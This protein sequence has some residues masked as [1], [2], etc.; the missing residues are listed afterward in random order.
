MPLEREYKNGHFEFKYLSMWFYILKYDISYQSQKEQ[1]P[2]KVVPPDPAATTIILLPQI[3]IWFPMRNLT[4]LLPILL[5]TYFRCHL[6]Y[7]I[8]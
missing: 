5:I 1:T 3:M 8:R 6:K 4:K 2:W 7:I